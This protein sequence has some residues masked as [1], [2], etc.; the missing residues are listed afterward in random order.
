MPKSVVSRKKLFRE[1]SKMHPR[2]I[3]DNC[4]KNLIFLYREANER[5]GLARP[6]LDILLFVYDLEFFTVAYLAKTTG[7]SETQ[8]KKKF[9][10]KLVKDGF[11]Y[12]H[13]DKLTPSQSVEDFFFRDETKYNYRV[14]YAIT[15]RGRGIIARLYSK[16]RGD[17]KFNLSLRDEQHP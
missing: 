2:H 15:Q 8:L 17:A 6:E 12:K 1:F 5:Y 4:M 3:P 10:Y 11:L 7:K 9:I 16:M 13:F 14:R